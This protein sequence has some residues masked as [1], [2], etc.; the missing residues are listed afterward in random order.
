MWGGGATGGVRLCWLERAVGVPTRLAWREGTGGSTSTQQGA[1]AAAKE[2][3]VHQST[4]RPPDVLHD[5]RGSVHDSD[6]EVSLLSVTASPDPSDYIWV[7]VLHA[8]QPTTVH[9][10]D[11][12]VPGLA[13]PAPLVTITP[14]LTAS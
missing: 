7:P 1:G 8:R 5:C 12:L 11:Q 14:R 9:G 10:C 3:A 6:I 13:R 4:L 2:Q